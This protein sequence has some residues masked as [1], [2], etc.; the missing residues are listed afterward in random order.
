MMRISTF[1]VTGDNSSSPVAAKSQNQN[2][3]TTLKVFADFADPMM[4]KANKMKS[5]PFVF[6]NMTY[7][8][9]S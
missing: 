3:K 6:L 2:K 4:Q 5:R 9:V 7:K 8:P 1:I